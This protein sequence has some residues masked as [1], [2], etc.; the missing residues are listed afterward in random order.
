[1]EKSEKLLEADELNDIQDDI[2]KFFQQGGLLASKLENYELREE[3]LQLSQQ[4]ASALA[5]AKHLIAEAG[6]GVGKTLAYLVA[7]MYYAQRFDKKIAISTETK[8]L[9]EQIVRKELPLL[10]SLG[11]SFHYSIA[12]GQ[13]NYICLRRLEEERSN[14]S[15]FPEDNEVLENLHAWANSSQTGLRHK[16]PFSIENNL[17]RKINRDPELSLNRSCPYSE[18]CFYLRAR[19]EWL[20]SDIVIFNHSLYLSILRSPNNFLRQFDLLIFDEAHSLEKLV[21]DQMMVEI[22]FDRL[23]SLL[24]KFWD[25]KKIKYIDSSLSKNHKKKIETS[26]HNVQDIAHTF[27]NSITV[28]EGKEF[29]RLD[30]PLVEIHNLFTAIKNLKDTLQKSLE[31]YFASEEESEYNSY[32]ENFVTSLIQL[33]DEMEILLQ[34]KSFPDKYVAWI[35][36]REKGK[37]SGD[38]LTYSPYAV[39]FSPLELS[40]IFD[41]ILSKIHKNVVFLSATL[42]VNGNFNHYRQK[43]GLFQDNIDSALISSPFDYEG[44]AILYTSKHVADPAN[45]YDEYI[46]NLSYIVPR[47]IEISHGRA[48]VLFTSYKTMQDTFQAIEVSDSSILR[49]DF[50]IL[51]QDSQPASLLI[52]DFM[53]AKNGILFGTASFWQGVDIPGSQ[54]EL[55]IIT[56][57]PFESPDN[58]VLEAKYDWYKRKGL[59]PFLHYS[60][61]NT[62]IRLKQGFGRLIRRKSDIGIVAVLDSRLYSRSYGSLIRNSLPPAKHLQKLDQVEKAFLDLSNKYEIKRAD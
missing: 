46:S 51:L 18:E 14:G 20:Q 38:L 52:Q 11:F 28:A 17:W 16:I 4:I 41:F 62:V 61:G 6:T 21:V 2:K 48:L 43:L 8:A 22:S 27:F 50:E 9:Q 36:R 55:V 29:K 7:S 39:F 34:E 30:K 13:S 10:R 59:N 32:F 56:R 54:L 3:Q 31:E 35:R 23:N 60:V 19:Q 5:Q 37:E 25:G 12:Y 47:L 53:Q 57:L 26:L 40:D 33:K 45:A 49:G 44:Q 42:S 15:L 24:Q 58:P 1:M